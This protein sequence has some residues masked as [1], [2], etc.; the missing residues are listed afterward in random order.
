DP[1][2]RPAC[3]AGRA[4]AVP[5]GR[6]APGDPGQTRRLVPRPAAGRSPATLHDVALH[7]ADPWAIGEDLTPDNL[8]VFARTSCDSGCSFARWIAPI[9]VARVFEYTPGRPTSRDARHAR[10]PRRSMASNR[11][12]VPPGARARCQRARGVSGSGLSRR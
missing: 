11:A 7:W 9:S 12:A 4:G 5:H 10:S 6:G 8:T 1:G 2:A 3:I